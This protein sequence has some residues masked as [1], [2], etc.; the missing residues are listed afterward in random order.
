MAMV[1]TPSPVRCGTNPLQDTSK[2]AVELRHHSNVTPCSLTEKSHKGD[3]HRTLTLD[4]K[5]VDA[6]IYHS[7]G[8]DHFHP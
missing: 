3:K 5:L 8:V 4:D 7:C 1:P 2:I 6:L